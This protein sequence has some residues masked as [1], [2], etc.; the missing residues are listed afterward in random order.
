MVELDKE[1]E[2][3]RSEIAAFLREFADELTGMAVDPD[4]GSTAVDRE[5]VAD[6]DRTE[7]EME[8]ERITFIVGGDSATVTVPELVEFEVEVE[9]RSPLLGSGVNQE[10]TFEMSWQIDEQARDVHDD[11]IEIE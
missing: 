6:D 3:T 2:L 4:R 11:V 9:S 8:A 5:R 1:G 10:V 7:A